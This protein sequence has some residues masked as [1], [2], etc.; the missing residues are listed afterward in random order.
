MLEDLLLLTDILVKISVKCFMHAYSFVPF[1]S[2]YWWS[3]HKIKLVIITFVY[4]F[5]YFCFVFRHVCGP[6]VGPHNGSAC[7]L[8]MC[9]AAGSAQSEL[10]CVGNFRGLSALTADGPLDGIFLVQELSGWSVFRLN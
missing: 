9:G 10:L 4:L 8:L 2:A 3:C 5:I 6:V 7:I 1:L